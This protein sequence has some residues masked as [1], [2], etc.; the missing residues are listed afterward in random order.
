MSVLD[1]D[2]DMLLDLLADAVERGQRGA[3][4]ALDLALEELETTGVLSV[5]TRLAAKRHVRRVAA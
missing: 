1:I 2:A 3:Q 5:I 4:T